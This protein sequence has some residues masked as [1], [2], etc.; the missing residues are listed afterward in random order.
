MESWEIQNKAGFRGFCWLIFLWKKISIIFQ[1]HW[2]NISS[3]FKLNNLHKVH[4][5]CNS[6]CFQKHFSTMK[7]SPAVSFSTSSFIFLN[8]FLWV[9]LSFLANSSSDQSLP[10]W[11]LLFSYILLKYKLEDLALL[12]QIYHSRL[13]HLNRWWLKI[14]NPHCAAFPL[15]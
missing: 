14:R 8:A 5:T 11:D 7:A 4:F 15:S 3:S 9:P 13:L 10:S 1:V 12:W 6:C 2:K